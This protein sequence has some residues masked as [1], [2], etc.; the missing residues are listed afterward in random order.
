MAQCKGEVGLERRMLRCWD[1]CFSEM[2]N[3]GAPVRFCYSI[4]FFLPPLTVVW[5]VPPAMRGKRVGQGGAHMPPVASASQSTLS[6]RAI[7]HLALHLGC[8]K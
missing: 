5:V 2:A 1:L 4:S 7:C 3:L 6:L 8:E